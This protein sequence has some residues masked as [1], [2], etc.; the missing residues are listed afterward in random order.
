MTDFINYLKAKGYAYTTIQNYSYY[1]RHLEATG[2]TQ[3]GI[4]EFLSTFN[5]SLP[6]AALRQY[7]EYKGATGLTVRR[8]QGR[9]PKRLPKYLTLEEINRLIEY[10]DIRTKIMIMLSYEGGLR[11]SELCNLQK[12]DLDMVTLCQW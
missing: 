10:A 3:T 9:T 1:E 6:R 5:F 8:R 7:L 11:A 12:E 2:L 4:D